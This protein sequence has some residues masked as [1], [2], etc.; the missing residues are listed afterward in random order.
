MDEW[1]KKMQYIYT[2]KYHLAVKD[3]KIMKFAGKWMKLETP[4]KG[5]GDT[6]TQK[7]K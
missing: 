1:I 2:V 6:Q 5:R 7:D 3:P 4:I